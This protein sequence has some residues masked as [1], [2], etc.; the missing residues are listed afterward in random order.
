MVK[1]M[2]A[3]FATDHPHKEYRTLVIDP[4]ELW[5]PGAKTT[6]D[7]PLGL[8]PTSSLGIRMS[9]GTLTATTHVQV[10]RRVEHPFSP[11]AELRVRIETGRQH[12]IR[13]HLSLFGT[14][15]A[16]DKLY[17]YDDAFRLTDEDR[18]VLERAALACPVHRSLHPDM[19]IPVT[20]DWCR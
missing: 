7:T 8:C 12:Q 2:R 4:S 1:R 3:L 6:L 11:M 13:V 19:E 20:F 14:P 18:K 15:V 10:V 9:H 5:T 17:R 16:G